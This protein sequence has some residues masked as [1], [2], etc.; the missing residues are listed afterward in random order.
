MEFE[1]VQML[2]ATNFYALFQQQLE[3]WL[4]Q[5]VGKSGE[6]FRTRCVHMCEAV[7][8]DQYSRSTDPGQIKSA[9]ILF[10]PLTQPTNFL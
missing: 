7:G 10:K 8:K 9:D 4:A 6:I 3:H 1:T 2:W 5:A